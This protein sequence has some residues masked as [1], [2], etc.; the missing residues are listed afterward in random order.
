MVFPSVGVAACVIAEARGAPT[1][2]KVRPVKTAADGGMEPLI[3]T[4][5][6]QAGRA[7]I[8]RKKAQ[9]AQK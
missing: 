6:H 9:E 1:V 5:W 3:F 4:N 7:E 8:G 2:V